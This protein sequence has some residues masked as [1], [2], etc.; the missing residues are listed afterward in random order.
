MQVLP[1][2][3][4]VIGRRVSWARFLGA[5]DDCTV[6]RPRRVAKNQ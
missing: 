2:N 4:A 5:L 1:V 6:P 3:V